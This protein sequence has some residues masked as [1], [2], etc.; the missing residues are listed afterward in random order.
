MRQQGKGANKGREIAQV[1][2]VGKWK[3][4]HATGDPGTQCGASRPPRILPAEGVRELPDVGGD[5]P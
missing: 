1:S 2:A 3:E 4:L 5:P